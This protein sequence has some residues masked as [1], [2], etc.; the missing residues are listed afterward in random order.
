MKPKT[1]I[2]QLTELVKEYEDWIEKDIPVSK[3]W[4]EEIEYMIFL[5]NEIDR[6]LKIASR[7]QAQSIDTLDKRWVRLAIN[8]PESKIIN[9]E[10]V[11]NKGKWW[12]K[13]RR[14]TK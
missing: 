13:L 10:I 1:L 8:N 3:D 12:G 14:F 6:L 5:R 9:E 7:E 11:L 4:F 2:T